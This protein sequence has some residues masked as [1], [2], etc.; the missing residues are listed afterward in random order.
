MTLVDVTMSKACCICHKIATE[1][2]DVTSTRQILLCKR[3]FEKVEADARKY[4]K[5]EK[6]VLEYIEILKFG[7]E[8][9]ATWAR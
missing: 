2:L 7:Y 5:T 4:K 9:G 8:N 1:S 6:E 3:H